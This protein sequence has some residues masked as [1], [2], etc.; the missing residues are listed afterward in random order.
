MPSYMQPHAVVEKFVTAQD[1]A[2]HAFTPDC[3][4]CPP[5][6]QTPPAVNCES[7]VMRLAYRRCQEARREWCRER[8]VKDTWPVGR[9]V[10]KNPRAS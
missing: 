4:A 6:I 9:P 7:T 5:V 8:Q 2:A 10:W 3:R 1:L